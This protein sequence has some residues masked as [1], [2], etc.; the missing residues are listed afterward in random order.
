VAW[1]PHVVISDI[2]MPQ[3]DGYSLVRWLRSLPSEEGG[4]VPAI[5]VTAY[6]GPEDRVRVLAAGFTLHITKPIQPDEIAIA[7]AN[8]VRRLP[9]A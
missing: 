6:T 8:V 2:Q 1:R 4:R 7:V 5:A 9:A 3:E